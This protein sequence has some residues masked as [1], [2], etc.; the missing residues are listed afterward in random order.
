MRVSSCFLLC[1]LS[2][3]LVSGITILDV[4]AQAMVSEN[5]DEIAQSVIDGNVKEYEIPSYDAES[6]SDSDSSSG[7]RLLRSINPQVIHK[8]VINFTIRFVTNLI[9]C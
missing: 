6:D 4:P 2:A 8:I 1:L 7:R 9:Y 5:N 3:S